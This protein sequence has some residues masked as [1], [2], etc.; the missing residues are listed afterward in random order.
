[1]LDGDRISQQSLATSPSSSCRLQISSESTSVDE[2]ESKSDEPPSD[3]QRLVIETVDS[4]NSMFLQIVDHFLN[5]CIITPL[6]V[7]FW[8]SSWDII[9]LY[10]YPKN[11]KISYLITFALANSIL[12]ASYFLQHQL[13]VYHDSTISRKTTQPG[14]KQAYYDKRFLIRILYTYVLT[15]AYVAQ[16]RTYWDLYNTVAAKVSFEYFLGI[17]IFTLFVYRYVLKC[18]FGNFAKT[19]PFHLQ[20]D[21]AFSEYF[22]QSKVRHMTNVKIIF[23]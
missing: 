2:L 8:A 16:W 21:L 20:P 9:Y 6:I 19:I 15:W 13:Q 12:L 10:L 22:T 4:S 3:Q 17:S 7:F 14:Y 23:F 1:M 11:L 18:S 5:L